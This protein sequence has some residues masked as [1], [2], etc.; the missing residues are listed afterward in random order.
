LNKENKQYQIVN[1]DVKVTNMH[2]LSFIIACSV[3]S[4]AIVLLIF[5]ISTNLCCRQTADYMQVQINT[6][7]GLSRMLANTSS[8]S[9]TRDRIF[10][11][12]DRARVSFSNIVQITSS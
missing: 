1:G 11:P 6:L 10:A 7:D 8:S 5:V 12:D 4:F 9:S 2:L 3:V